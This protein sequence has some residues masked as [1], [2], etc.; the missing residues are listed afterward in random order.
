MNRARTTASG[1]DRVDELADLGER[2]VLPVGGEG[3]VVERHAVGAHDVA[4][5][6]V[7]ADHCFQLGRE[8]AGGDPAEQVVQAVRLLAHQQHR[9]LGHAGVADR[10]RAPEGVR[11]LAEARPQLVDVEGQGARE[12]DL[13]REEPPGDGIGVIAGLHDPAAC[14]G[15]E[16]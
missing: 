9:P 11:D 16:P 14:A 8:L 2:L 6:V 12:H 15:E 7:V 3:D 1:R 5:R 13:A 10:P 4:Q